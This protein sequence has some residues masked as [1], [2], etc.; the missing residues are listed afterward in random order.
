MDR[1]LLP[2]KR[3]R[4]TSSLN[5]PDKI[6]NNTE[7]AGAANIQDA[8]GTGSNASHSWRD[9]DHEAAL[10]L[11]CL[12]DK[13]NPASGGQAAN[14]SP[15]VAL[16]SS[17]DAIGDKLHDA[18]T[19]MAAAVKRNAAL[20]E[21]AASIAAQHGMSIMPVTSSA[22]QVITSSSVLDERN[23]ASTPLDQQDRHSPSLGESMQLQGGGSFAK[24]FPEKL[25]DML[26]TEDESEEGDGGPPAM[27]WLP[28][29]RSFV[30]R[31]K[32]KLVTKLLPRHH[33]QKCKK[34]GSFTRRLYLWGFRK[35]QHGPDA[36]AFHH[37][38]F[39]RGDRV[40]CL[41]MKC[42]RKALF[43]GRH[44]KKSQ[45]QRANSSIPLESWDSKPHA[46]TNASQDNLPPSARTIIESSSNDDKSASH[47]A[48]PQQDYEDEL[49]DDDDD[50]EEDYDYDDENDDEDYY[51]LHSLSS[52]ASSIN[53]GAAASPDS[54]NEST[55]HHLSSKARGSPQL[56]FPA[57]I[58]HQQDVPVA[59]NGPLSMQISLSGI[60]YPPSIQALVD[61]ID[62][63]NL[64]L[65]SL[66]G[67]TDSSPAM[68]HLYQA[69]SESSIDRDSLT[70]WLLFHHQKKLFLRTA[71]LSDMVRTLTARRQ[72]EAEATQNHQKRSQQEGMQP[73]QQRKQSHVS[74][75]DT[76]PSPSQPQPQQLPPKR[77]AK[78]PKMQHSSS[79]GEHSRQQPLQP[80][81]HTSNR[82]LSSTSASPNERHFPRKKEAKRAMSAAN[83]DGSGKTASPPSS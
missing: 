18:E 66:L 45:N 32:Q 67:G 28:H 30:I 1:S 58:Q 4:D 33:F 7:K 13:N 72:A 38:L 79:S 52:T 24:T 83:C 41:H 6:M 12:S 43:Q 65:Q 21:L 50:E 48:K 57:P 35:V 51:N 16:Y 68:M 14:A 26:E 34:F 61:Q 77:Q 46:N 70:E 76:H 19:V 9:R 59:S 31:N 15:K 80:P 8:E 54:T 2:L 44:H 82:K 63:S 10:M 20:C 40:S 78:Q 56:T 29:G 37:D 22:L 81:R 42:N 17:D 74:H 5:G 75:Q 55:N 69:A 27:S 3:K 23:G 71:I 39:R 73:P 47:N 62:M 64:S 53:G 60:T 11:T 36:G 25:H 49:N